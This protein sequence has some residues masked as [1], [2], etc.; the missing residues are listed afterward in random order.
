MRSRIAKVDRHSSVYNR[1]KKG[2]SLDLRT[3]RGKKVFAA[4]VKTADMFCRTSGPGSWT[5]WASAI[6]SSAS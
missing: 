4:L 3:E 5:R 2:L 1:G 6:K